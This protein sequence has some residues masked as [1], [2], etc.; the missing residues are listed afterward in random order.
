MTFSQQS[1]EARSQ[2]GALSDAFSGTLAGHRQR[3]VE[4]FSAAAA[5]AIEQMTVRAEAFRRH[6]GETTQRTI[7]DFGANVEAIGE[8][9]ATV[10]A[11]T[12]E[13]VAGHATAMRENFG[14]A[15]HET[16][17]RL[18]RP[19]RGVQRPVRAGRGRRRGIDL[20]PYRQ[21]ARHCGSGDPVQPRRRRRKGRKHQA[22]AGRADRR[23]AR[24]VRIRI[25]PDRKRA[26]P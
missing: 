17:G 8:A 4:E 13:D 5:S 16:L 14:Q 21:S 10:S 6:V 22:A 18:R 19:R 11:R 20:G 24:A 2:L 7:E 26:R 9:Y 25:R 1:E 12:A 15:A 3:A 23:D